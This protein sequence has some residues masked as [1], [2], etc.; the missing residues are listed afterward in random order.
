MIEGINWDHCGT[1]YLTPGIQFRFSSKIAIRNC[2]FQYSKGLALALSDVSGDVS[3]YQCK[4]VNCNNSGG[5]GA[6]IHYSSS[7]PQLALMISDC[8]FSHNNGES[9]LHV[10]ESATCIIVKNC[11]FYKNKG[12][13]VY[14]S[15][16]GLK[17]DGYLFID[18]NS[19]RNGGGI[20]IGSH[21][22]IT[23]CKNSIAI[24]KNNVAN[25][26]GGAIYI[27]DSACKSAI[28]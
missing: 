25:N 2:S 7:D 6:A 17:F 21:T 28:L 8:E 24:S 4:F 11:A 20:V 12:V 14:I 23:F 10:G 9:V 16:K 3:I 27:D 13:P 19:A 1:E 5:Y 18:E 22:N 15:S 26:D